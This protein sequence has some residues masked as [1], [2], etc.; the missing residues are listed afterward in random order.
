VADGMGGHAAGEVASR[1]AVDS[2]A[3]AG[4]GADADAADIRGAFEKA[5]E[6]VFE[7]ATGPAQGMG[8]TCSLLIIGREAAH[9][10]HVGD[11]RVYL[12]RG[13]SLRALTRDHT[14]VADLVERGVLTDD[15]ARVDSK[16]GFVTRAL[17]GASRVEPDMRTV[18]IEDGDR[19]LLCSDGLTSMVSDDL[20]KSL[21]ATPDPQA[22]AEALVAAANDAGGDDN[23]TALVVDP[24]AVSGAKSAARP[25][26]IAV[27]QAAFIVLVLLLGVLA[28]LLFG[29]PLS[30]PV[31]TASPELTA[32]PAESTPSAVPSPRSPLAPT[33]LVSPLAP[34]SASPS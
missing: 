13:D 28:L 12:L 4:L 2:L 17:G 22:A 5:N 34:A 26:R 9:V 33:P 16:R 1:L 14:V 19:F 6:V 30:G 11:S 7:E 24:R 18:D 27:V 8:T 20:I 29:G 32:P 3:R 23:V 15:Q 21:L 25:R 10:G 31:T